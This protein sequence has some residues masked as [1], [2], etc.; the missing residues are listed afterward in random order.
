MAAWYWASLKVQIGHTKV[1]VERHLDIGVE[2]ISVKLHVY[3]IHEIIVL[4]RPFHL[5]L[6][7][8]FK[9]VIQRSMYKVTI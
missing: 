1:N 5:E 4:T 8:K 2:N 9:K 7:W 6:V 3:V